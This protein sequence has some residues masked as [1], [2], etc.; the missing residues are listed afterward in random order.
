M[1]ITMVV[2]GIVVMFTVALVGTNQN[3]FGLARR[4]EDQSAALALANGGLNRY[5]QRVTYDGAYSTDLSYGTPESGYG[6]TFDTASPDRSVN[7]L[8]NDAASLDTNYKGQTVPPHTIDLIVVARS[9]QVKRRFRYVLRRGL[10]FQGAMAA[11]RRLIFGKDVKLESITSLRDDTPVEA[12]FHSND[13]GSSGVGVTWDGTGTFQVGTDCEVTSASLV[14]PGIVSS[15]PG[16]TDEKVPPLT[17]TQ[18]NIQ[19][20]VTDASSSPAPTAVMP[21]GFYCDGN[22]YLGTT[23][24]VN[25]DISLYNGSLYV[26]GDLTIN[27]GVIGYGS[28][29]A[30]GNVYI[31][32]GNASVISNQPNGAAILAGGDITFEGLDAAGYI[33]A[34]A[35]TDSNVATTWTR[36]K[37]GYR[38]LNEVTA[39]SNSP[40]SKPLDFDTV[41]PPPSSDPYGISY[42]SPGP[43]LQ[44]DNVHWAAYNISKG[45]DIPAVM[46]ISTNLT[47][48]GPTAPGGT[49]LQSPRNDNSYSK[50]LQ[51]AVTVAAGGDPR[52][53]QIARALEQV[54]YYFRHGFYGAT[55]G[56]DDATVPPDGGFGY[57]LDHQFWIA[58]ALDPLGTHLPMVYPI[59]MTPAQ[60]AQGVQDYFKYH[61]P[62]NFGWLGKSYFQG[63]LYARGN[64]TIVNKAVIIGSVVSGGDLTVA[65]GADFTYDKEYDQLTHNLSGPVKVASFHEL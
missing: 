33:D 30:T 42:G 63:V 2:I 21:S 26:Q 56:W 37:E 32:G 7:N 10:A 15:N 60:M 45:N 23:T 61:D 57:S 8:A 9:H 52:G 40:Y 19:Q 27:G 28:I 38:V 41:F 14:D 17:L 62:L 50:S 58:R 55:L 18:L 11:S 6:I 1:L 35:A 12:H 49:L 5:L 47:I 3:L 22:R 25:G 43:G 39:P 53:G 29:Y 34:L 16:K 46:G 48:P 20:L 54:G 64:V 65:D 24:T 13:D 44:A 51:D 36:F 31:R 4:T 59:P